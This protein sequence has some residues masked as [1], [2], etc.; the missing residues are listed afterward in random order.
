MQTRRVFLSLT[1]AAALLGPAAATAD[2]ELPQRV[3]FAMNAPDRPQGDYFRD[4]DRR[5][6]EVL[7]YLELERGMTVLDLMAGTGYYTEILSAAV[8][9]EG[10]VY[11]H[12]DVMAL[13]QRHG[14]IQRAMDRR[15]AANRLPNA[16]IWD[17]DITDL[18]LDGTIDA[19]TLVLNLHDLYGFGGEEKV[20]AAL[21]G[22]MRALKPGGI[23]G[24]VDH[25]GA[26]GAD[27]GYLHR[28]DPAVAAEL[29]SKA[30]FIIVGSS[31]L[32]ANPLDDHTLHVYDPAI[33]GR[34]DRFIIKAMKPNF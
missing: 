26:A 27:N 4:G 14:A 17:K 33:R 18:K 2:A 9:P 22:V 23:L 34:T 21:A 25:A 10:R 24:V 8:G 20:L 32:L 5:P 30:G 28:I 6:I 16:Q 13:R 31:D 1:L 29:L 11:S 15:L 19:A 12:N 3:F 7:T